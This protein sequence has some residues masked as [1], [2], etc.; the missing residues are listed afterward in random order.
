[1]KTLPNDKRSQMVLVAVGTLVVIVA[2]YYGL[3]SLQRNTLARIGQQIADQENKVGSAQRLVGTAKETEARLA[4][5]KARLQ[6]VEQTMASGDLYSW[7]ILTVNKFRADRAVDIPQFSR[8][9]MGE[10]GMFPKFPYKAAIFNLRGTAY[11]HDFGK[12]VAD[13]ENA[14]PHLR[15]QNLNLDPAAASSATA[16]T[17]AEKLAFKMEVVALVNPEAR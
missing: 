6:S 10:V 4:M 2:I 15:V 11:F 16:T 9:T 5:A 12:F 14:F 7:I 8:E 1:M 17:D 3:I 13:F